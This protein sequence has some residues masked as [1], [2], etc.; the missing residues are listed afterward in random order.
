MVSILL[1]GCCGRMGRMISDLAAQNE[2]TVIAAGV[3]LAPASCN[4]PV[5][6]SLAD[7]HVP[8]DILVDFTR[9]DE[10][11]DSIAYCV[12]HHMALLVGT[13]GLSASQM[14]ILYRAAAVIPVFWASNLSMG[15]ALLERLCRNAASFLQGNFDVEITET[16]HKG[17][18]DAPSGT[19][20][21]L[22]EAI[23]EEL[24]APSP[25]IHGRS[26]RCPRNAGEIGIH[27]L[28]GGT[29]TGEHQVHFFGHDETITLSHSAQ[30]RGVF[31]A[32]AIRAA[33]WVSD[34]PAGFY[35]MKDLVAESSS[36]SSLTI[37][38]GQVVTQPSSSA[39]AMQFSGTHWLSF[40]PCEEDKAF[41]SLISWEYP[42]LSAENISSCL[43]RIRSLEIQPLLVQAEPGKLLLA[44]PRAAA[45]MVLEVIESK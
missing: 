7:C 42:S 10:V 3:D 28:R 45:R 35:S 17:K 12:A 1:R 25:F 9:A 13:T 33:L 32:G 34:K 16:H 40:V 29:V 2:E 20:L 22:A 31:A 39:L 27:A 37:T 18:L 30:S 38:Q 26:G 15:V 5:F 6:T 21:T 8:A 36:S 41:A 11:E 23:R 44:V 14:E 24:N 4:Y 19:A 43:N